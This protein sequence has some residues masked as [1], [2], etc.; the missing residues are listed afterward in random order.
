MHLTNY[1]VNKKNE[2]YNFNGSEDYKSTGS[3]RTFSH[4][5]SYLK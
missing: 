1:S 2:N 5:M 3:K 4:I